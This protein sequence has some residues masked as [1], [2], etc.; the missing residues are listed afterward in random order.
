MDGWTSHCNDRPTQP[1]RL[2]S[3]SP[4]Q[5]AR[6]CQLHYNITDIA[7]QTL[8]H[9]VVCNPTKLFNITYISKLQA[10]WPQEGCPKKWDIATQQRM[11]HHKCC[12]TK[13]SLPIWAHNR[14]QNKWDIASPQRLQH[15]KITGSNKILKYNTTEFATP[16]SLQHHKYYK[17]TG[18]LSPGRT[19]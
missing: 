6:C 3:H 5:V 8:L 15:H 9:H 18:H 10:I 17:I 1:T 13:R 4:A 7:T 12:N 11:Q 2:N 16:Q 14:L 19:S